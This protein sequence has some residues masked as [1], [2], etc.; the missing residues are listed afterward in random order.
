[1]AQTHTII[2]LSDGKVYA[3]GEEDNEQEDERLASP[4]LDS[5]EDEPGEQ[6][7]GAERGRVAELSED[8]EL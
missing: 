2:V 5:G 3:D 8:D 4:V 7:G 1:M 6:E